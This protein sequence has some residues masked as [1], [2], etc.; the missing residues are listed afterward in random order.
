MCVQVCVRV[1]YVHT[2][3][4]QV[5]PAGSAQLYRGLEKQYLFVHVCLSTVTVDMDDPIW[6]SDGALN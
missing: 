5:A 6:H 3:V 2:L 1:C 4:Q